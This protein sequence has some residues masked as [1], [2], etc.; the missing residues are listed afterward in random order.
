M[1][2]YQGTSQNF[3]R[4][5]ADGRLTD[6]I[7]MA[8][9][10]RYHYAPEERG[11]Q[12][13]GRY[14]RSLAKVMDA[15]GLQDSGVI[16][17]YQLPSSSQRLD[18]V[19]TG[20]DDEGQENVVIIE[21]KDWQACRLADGGCE[22]IEERHGLPI[23]IL[24]PSVQAMQY[25]AYLQGSNRAFQDDRLRLSTCTFLPEYDMKAE[26]TLLDEMFH[27]YLDVSPVFAYN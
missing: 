4:D 11:L 13:F 2:L 9:F 10:G 1:L 23:E 18:C 15:A 5:A 17:K 20:R 6:R 7:E 19:V 24:H 8:F 27:T 14:L 21:M 26:D 3:I 22:L 25:R 12:T 16:L